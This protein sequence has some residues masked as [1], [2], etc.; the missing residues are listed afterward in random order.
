MSEFDN[1][2]SG[3]TAKKAEPA[4]AVQFDNIVEGGDGKKS[5]RQIMAE[6]EAKCYAM[7]DDACIDVFTSPAKLCEYLLVQSC[8]EKYS[9]NNNILIFAQN[10]GAT[11]LKDFNAWKK[12][13]C[14]VKK[15]A[16]SIMILEPSPYTGADGKPHRGYNA[17]NV[18]DIEDVNVSTKAQ[19]QEKAYEQKKLIE[20][21]VHGSP[22][23]IRRTEQN[24]GENYAVY[25]AQNKVIFFK[26]GLEFAQVFPA[27]AKALAHAEMAKGNTNYRVA[28][29]EFK[30]RCSAN[31]IAQKYGVDIHTVD[32]HV[33]PP[34]YASLEAEDVKKEL[35]AVY[36][37]VKTITARMAEVLDKSQNKEQTQQQAQT[38]NKGSRNREER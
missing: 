33:I 30:A 25:D 12:D 18:F 16:E 21:L 20:A 4:P 13:G 27:I 28:D 6:K 1:V 2:L 3:V 7:I 34:K 11:K 8:F 5:Y 15:G 10:P 19:S 31:I 37:N 24:F 9:L 22:V 23:P 38:Q 29:N 32:I 14:S 26:P 17:K 35:G 36:D